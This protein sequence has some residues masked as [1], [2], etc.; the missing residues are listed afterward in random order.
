MQSQLSDWKQTYLDTAEKFKGGE[1]VGWGI[2][3][4][5]DQQM[6]SEE[7]TKQLVS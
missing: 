3:Y 5:W 6:F 7:E 1:N 2:I 4:S